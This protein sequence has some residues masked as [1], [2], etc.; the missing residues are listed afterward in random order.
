MLLKFGILSILVAALAAGQQLPGQGQLDA[1]PS[2]FTVMAAINAAGFDQGIDSPNNHPLRKAVREHIAKQTIPCMED[3]KDFVKKHRKGSASAEL[4]QYI[5]FA[6]S[7]S[8]PPGFQTTFRDHEIPLDVLTL[9]GFQ[10]LMIRFHREAKMDDLWKAVQPQIE[11]VIEAYHEPVTNAVREANGYLRNV[12]SGYVGRKYQIFFELLA[13]PNNVQTR[14][15]KDDFFL[16]ITPTAEMLQA[17][18]TPKAGETAPSPPIDH[19]RYSY[20]QY[21][22]DPLSIKYGALIEK[23][24]GLSDFAR[25]AP[26]LDDFYK[27]D[28]ILL[29]SV[30]VMKAIDAKLHGKTGQAMVDQAFKEGFILTPHFYEQLPAFEKS[31]QTFRLYYP[32]LITSIDLKKEDKRLEGVQFAAAKTVK[33]IKVAS[34]EEPVAKLSGAAKT[35]AAAEELFNDRKDPKSLE[36]A[37]GLFLQSLEQ[38]DEKPLHAKSYY[39]LARV[40]ASQQNRELS[41]KLFQKTL[42]LDPDPRTKGWAHFYLGQLAAMAGEADVSKSHYESVLKIDGAAEKTRQA[43]EQSL[44]KVLEKSSQN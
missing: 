18:A 2:L 43:A 7:T 8:G 3:L 5:S 44:K 30:C 37:R 4:S 25:A 11:Q 24:R 14:S 9:T 10:E 17:I 22:L 19:I 6:L 32:D 39:G 29:T 21:L 36:K 27:E 31:E 20:L 38:T 13:P 28:F 41:E 12:T 1:S 35:L 40:A 23:K 16:V 26:A 15:Y 34:R 33:T 42:E